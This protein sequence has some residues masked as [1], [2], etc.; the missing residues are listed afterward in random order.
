MSL[1]AL[2]QTTCPQYLRKSLLF[3]LKDTPIR[4]WNFFH[5]ARVSDAH[6]AAVAIRK[7]LSP[8]QI[9]VGVGYSMGAI[10]LNN[11]VAS[12]GHVC[13]LDGAFSI[14]GA[15]DCRYE[16][17]DWRSKILWQ[18]MLADGLKKRFLLGKH[19]KK[20]QERMTKWEYI[21]LL[22]ANSVVVSAV[23][24]CGRYLSWLQSPSDL[25][26]ERKSNSDQRM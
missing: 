18:P 21:H 2:K 1:I 8:A 19:G 3:G 4:S 6:D 24:K 20:L 9:L 23:V 7:A 26:N 15:L 22:R 14:S 11:Y 12:S 5:G 10:V 17:N 13:A 25:T 16:L